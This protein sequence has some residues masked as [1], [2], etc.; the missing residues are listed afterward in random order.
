[1]WFESDQNKGT[2]FYFTIKTT[3]SVPSRVSEDASLLAG[4]SV[5]IVDPSV[6]FSQF[7]WKRLKAW[8]MSVDTVVST[9]QALDMNKEFDLF[10]IDSRQNIEEIEKIMEMKTKVILLGASRQTELALPFLIKPIRLTKLKLVLLQLFGSTVST[11][12]VKPVLAS[13]STTLRIL[14]AEDNTMNQKVIRKV[15]DS[16]GYKK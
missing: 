1:M 4:K 13:N 5:L 6:D 3:K 14:V 11:E 7:L 2:T 16:L 10:L 9:R 8:G 15:L 12:V